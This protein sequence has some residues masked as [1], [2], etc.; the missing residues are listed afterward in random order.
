MRKS[1]LLHQAEWDIEDMKRHKTHKTE[2][3]ITH[4]VSSAGLITAHGAWLT[5]LPDQAA[6]IGLREKEKP[7]LRYPKKDNIGNFAE[8]FVSDSHDEKIR[9]CE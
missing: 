8:E 6:R 9:V 4:I 3:V 2:I 7:R 1:I 5:P